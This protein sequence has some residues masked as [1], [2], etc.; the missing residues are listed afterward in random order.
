MKQIVLAMTTAAAVVTATPLFAQT[1]GTARADGTQLA[2]A[3]VDVRVGEPRRPG[4]V[5][6]EPRRPGVVIEE[7]RRRDRDVV[8]GT[9]GRGRGDCRS[10]TVSEWRDGVRVSRTERRCD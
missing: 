5:I 7:P 6:E 9:E 1:T 3:G 4:V 2:Q 10:V 8:I